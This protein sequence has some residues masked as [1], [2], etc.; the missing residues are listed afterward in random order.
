MLGDQIRYL[1]AR[2][3]GDG[4]DILSLGASLIENFIKIRGQFQRGGSGRHADVKPEDTLLPFVDKMPT[5][6]QKVEPTTVARLGPQQHGEAP[7]FSMLQVL[8][9]AAGPRREQHDFSFLQ[10]PVQTRFHQCGRKAALEGT[11][12]LSW[13]FDGESASRNI[14]SAVLRK[15]SHPLVLGDPFLRLTGT[16]TR[17]QHRI[18]RILSGRFQSRRLA[19]NFFGS[20][21]TESCSLHGYL[22][23]VAATAIPDSG[24]ECCLM[25]AA[26]ARRHGIKVDSSPGSQYELEFLDGSVA[27]TSGIAKATWE[28][29]SHT[30]S[31]RCDFLVLE[32]LPVD[33][34]FSNDF[35]ERFDVFRL[36]QEMLVI[37][38][39]PLRSLTLSAF[40]VAI[41]RKLDVP[42]SDL[43]EEALRDLEFPNAFSA[44]MIIK[45]GAR[46]NKIQQRIA[47]L[48]KSQREVAQ[49][50]ELDRQLEWRRRKLAHKASQ[51]R[52]PSAQVPEVNG[53]V[54]TRRRWLIF[55]R[56]PR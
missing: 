10:W 18:K 40:G 37:D 47:Q 17:F 19:V 2:P 53:K 30:T 9:E 54:A 32:G 23:G 20:E 38:G 39:D 33:I 21:N 11:V 44:E 48:S 25:S 34:L 45:E 28:F 36:H 3:G 27:T 24:S 35:V 29:A 16:L 51:G 50:I 14:T 15:C 56:S 5:S 46:Q 22:N 49:K 41:L 31:V 1:Q 42:L 55:G 7:A 6:T 52:P 26:Y 13:K 8:L 43:V 4:V 12:E